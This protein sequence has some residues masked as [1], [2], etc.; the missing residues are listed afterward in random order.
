MAWAMAVG[1]ISGKD[2]L[3]PSNMFV[4]NPSSGKL[5]RYAE[6]GI[7][8]TNDNLEV[9]QNS[10]VVLLCVKPQIFPSV[11]KQIKESGKFNECNK[12]IIS[13]MAGVTNETMQQVF[14]KCHIVRTLPNTAALVQSGMTIISAHTDVPEP[15]IK[16]C[17]EILS[18]CGDVVRLP[19]RL[20]NAGMSLSGCG[21]GYVLCMIDAF[22]DGGVKMGLPRQTALKLA[23]SMIVGAGKMFLETGVHPVALK[24][25]VTSP[26]GTTIVGLHELERG[27]MRSMIMNAVEASTLKG[28]QLCRD[29]ADNKK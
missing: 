12:L 5:K 15:E 20:I 8:T 25:T 24:D 4:S 10:E 6:K 1:F 13:I 16:Y 9:L 19:E 2:G 28:E 22:A 17:E 3:T 27:G 18:R 29:S 23:A 14:P 26:G 11:A 21:I 7:H